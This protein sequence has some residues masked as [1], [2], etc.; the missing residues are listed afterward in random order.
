MGT[1]ETPRRTLLEGT[2]RE[3]GK[4]PREEGLGRWNA[5]RGREGQPRAATGSPSAASHR[6]GDVASAL[7][8]LT[9]TVPE[10]QSL[11]DHFQ[12]FASE[13][14]FPPS[15]KITLSPRLRQLAPHSF[16]SL[17]V[18]PKNSRP[19]FPSAIC[20]LRA[21]LKPTPNTDLQPHRSTRAVLAHDLR[22]AGPV[23]GSQ[24]SGSMT[25]GGV[26]PSSSTCFVPRALAP[27]GAPAH[28][29]PAF[30]VLVSPGRMSQ[31]ERTLPHCSHFLGLP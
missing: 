24:P 31:G 10:F 26:R 13:L 6:A 27:L 9:P 17:A 15:S 30:L 12:R 5:R 4:R 16:A 19:Y 20:P 11:P 3:D 1:T 2:F 22:T 25:G 14:S 23:L 7:S 8:A 28:P 29:R 21:S 18:T